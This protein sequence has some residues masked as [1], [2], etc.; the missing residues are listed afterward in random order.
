[1][2]D[3]N[4][5][6]VK[7]KGKPKRKGASADRPAMKRKQEIV[8]SVA[9]LMK[10]YKTIAVVNLRELPDRQFSSIRKKLRGKAEFIV[11]RNTLI[12]RAFDKAKVAT[13]LVGYVDSP[14]ALIFTDM[15]PF[16]LFN[17]LKKNKGKAAAKPGQIAPFDIIVP[18]GDTSLPPGPV[19]SELKGAKIDARIQ[20]GK[21]VIG[22]D[23]TVAKKGEKI[24][25][26][27]AKGLQKLGVQ[28]FE[29]GVNMVAAFEDGLVYKHDVMDVDEEQLMG[30]FAQGFQNALN[31]STEIAYPTKANIEILL[32]K[33]VKGARGLAIEANIYE[34]EVIGDILAKAK[35]QH[36]VLAENVKSDAPA[37]APEEKKEEV[38]AEGEKKVEGGEKKEEAKEEDD[39]SSGAK[40]PE[41]K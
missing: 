39:T 16:E 37:P 29:V 25:G 30:Q 5:A 10:K 32:G 9:K 14:S 4:V 13:E 7:V 21:V 20:G 15:N 41:K 6:K 19:L 3:K 35:R 36:D 40:A 24:S 8:S 26:A 1:M 27:V 11:A 34:K 18:A 31:L 12:K 28:P 23:S 33:A 17:F 38:K 2:A 22:K